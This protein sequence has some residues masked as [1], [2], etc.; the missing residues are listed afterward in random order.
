MQAPWHEKILVYRLYEE[1]SADAFGELYDLYVQPIYRYIS[2][3]VRTTTIAEDL[4]A[5]VFL[6][7]WEYVQRREKKIDN[8]RAF[9]YS[10]ARNTVVDH[11]RSQAQGEILRD[12]E[13]MDSV[14]AP[15][16]Q[17]IARLVEIDSDL[18][19]VEQSLRHLKDEYRE[20]LILR[21]I[22]DYPIVDIAEI[23]GKS[24]G[25]VRVTLHRALNALREEIEKAERPS[26]GKKV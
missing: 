19:T 4:T 21:Y 13:E 11:Y 14:P 5:E 1:R 18:A 9:I 15:S 7:T 24:R 10:L 2:F 25:A 20:A 3:K 6:K 16:E 8:F 26:K 12:R 17:H 22:E 23:M